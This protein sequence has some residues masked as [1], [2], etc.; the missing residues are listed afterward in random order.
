ML[1]LEIFEYPAA[2]VKKSVTG[3]GAADKAQVQRMVRA[4]LGRSLPA[5]LEF[6]R[7]DVSD[8]LAIAIC[9]LQHRH[10][11]QILRPRAAKKAGPVPRV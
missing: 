8:A 1:G 9:H 2:L 4:I 11:Q 3:S 10:Q 7:E 5:N 6:Q